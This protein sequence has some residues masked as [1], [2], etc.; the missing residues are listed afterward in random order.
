MANVGICLGNQ[1]NCEPSQLI[2]TSDETVNR[3]FAK[4]KRAASRGR[5][6]LCF[7]GFMLEGELSHHLQNPSAG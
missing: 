6:F 4:T 2:A 7:L 1:D 3:R 5:P